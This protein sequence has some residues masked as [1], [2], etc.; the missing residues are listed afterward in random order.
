MVARDRI[1]CPQCL[2]YFWKYQNFVIIGLNGVSILLHD[3]GRF[4]GGDLG[5]QITAFIFVVDGISHSTAL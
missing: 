3:V 5:F 1:C 2:F 4:T